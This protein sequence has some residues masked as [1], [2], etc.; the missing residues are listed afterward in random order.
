[1]QQKSLFYK[2]GVVLCV[3]L[4]IVTSLKSIREP[5]LWW[6]YTTG[7]WMLDNQSITYADPFSYTMLGTEWIN[8]KWLFE[9]FI[10][11]AKRLAGVEAIFLIQALATLLILKFVANSAKTIR[12][13]K[14]NQQTPFYGLLIGLGLLLLCIDFRLISRP[15]MSSHVLTAVYL[16]LFWRYY[17]K[18]DK[19]ILWLIPLQL[20]WTNLHEAF[21]IGMVLIIAHLV[22]YLIQHKGLKSN[23]AT[24]PK[25]LSIASLGALFAICINPRGF[26]ML[27]HPFNIFTQLSDNQFTTELYSITSLEYWKPEAYI[28]LS[29]FVLGLSYVLGSGW[30][31]AKGKV[32]LDKIKHT[33]EEYGLGNGLLVFMLFYLSTTAYRNIPFFVIAVLPFIALFIQQLLIKLPKKQLQIGLTL[34]F[35]TLSYIGIV[36]GTTRKLMQSRDYYGLQVLSDY[37]PVDAANFIKE[38]DISGKCF[39]DY[40]SS[41]YL[42]WALQ[43]DFKTYIDLRDLDIFPSEFFQDF[44]KLV[45]VP[46]EFDL[47]DDSLN[48]DYIVLLNKQ[49]QPLNKHILESNRYDMVFSNPVASIHLKRTDANRALIQKF[50]FKT[51]DKKDIFS[52]LAVPNPPTWAKIIS[53]ILNPLYQPET[54]STYALD[55]SAA[56]FYLDLNEFELSN[57][58][59]QQAF[60]AGFQLENTYFTEGNYYSNLAYTVPS[61]SSTQ[62]INKALDAYD[63]CLALD[64]TYTNALVSK[65]SIFIQKGDLPKAMAY[66]VQACELDPLNAGALKYMAYCYKSMVYQSYINPHPFNLEKWVFYLKK[67]Q[68]I[69]GSQIESNLDLA[70]AYRLQNNCKNVRLHLKKVIGYPYFNPQQKEEIK[71]C[72]QHCPN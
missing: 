37:N 67:V 5:D 57:K 53:Q 21:G 12:A 15:E 16:S 19:T 38:H 31:Q 45:M 6:M 64:P 44:S 39:S 40:L 24:M 1:M 36:S 70:I 17:H 63:R 32:L 33:I 50:G 56:N 2:I 60:K 52:G 55:N 23:K 68:E 69:E 47:R 49:F 22:A 34:G 28:S 25:L 29:L 7:D 3:L 30:Q 10:S 20:L 35:L 26:V 11:L 71:R 54:Y 27:A 46:N 41:S 18:P 48:F 62:Y 61:E 43:P 14:P 8:V 51:N 66:L 72:L 9:V 42:L 59:I 4:A 13:F 58:R 65:G